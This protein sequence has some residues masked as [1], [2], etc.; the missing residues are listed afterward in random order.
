MIR[1]AISLATLLFTLQSFAFPAAN[2]EANLTGTIAVNGESFP[3][4]YN[5]KFIEAKNNGAELLFHSQFYIENDLASEEMVWRKLEDLITPD[6]VTM[7]LAYCT[8]QGGTNETV[9]VPAGTFE[10]CK[11]P[12]EGEALGIR[13]FSDATSTGF[14]WV[15]MAPF[16]L[17]KLQQVDFD[18]QTTI[19]LD[20]ELNT[21]ISAQP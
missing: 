6:L 9:T 1:L 3:A 17:V 14:I 12:T 11:L 18:G 4:R 15:G 21:Y 13:L 7:I 19:A 16:G 10:T 8:Q 5:Q 20:L 2:D